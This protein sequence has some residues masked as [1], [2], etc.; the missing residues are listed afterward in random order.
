M[1]SDGGNADK[2]GV[3]SSDRLPQVPIC[4]ISYHIGAVLAS[5]VFYGVRVVPVA[6]DMLEWWTIVLVCFLT[7]KKIL[8]WWYSIIVNVFPVNLYFLEVKLTASVQPRAVFF[9]TIFSF[10]P[11]YSLP[12]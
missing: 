9:S 5:I 1:R 8:Y 12:V 7:D 11:L 3:V 2:E 6:F 10:I 4:I